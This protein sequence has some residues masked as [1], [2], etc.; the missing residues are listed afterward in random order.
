MLLLLLLLLIEPDV[1]W[2]ERHETI[3]GVA[4]QGV[5]TVALVGGH[6]EIRIF[7]AEFLVSDILI[8]LPQLMMCSTLTSPSSIRQKNLCWE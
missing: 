5:T 1:E 3:R 8:T 7:L 2:I 6:L 4:C